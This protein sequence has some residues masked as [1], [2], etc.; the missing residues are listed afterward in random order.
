MQTWIALFRGINV[1][2]R[3]KMSMAAL[4]SVLET[5]GCRS[6]RTYIQSGNVVFNSAFKSKRNLSTRL[7]DVTE[8]EFG[9]R[10]SILLLSDS[11]FRSAVAGNPFPDAIAEPKTLHFFFLD[12]VPVAPDMD[13]I[14]KL[15]SSTERYELIGT[16][17]YLHTPNGF[18]RSKLAAG[19]ERRLGVASTA[20]NYTTIQNLL[21]MLDGS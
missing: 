21:S 12:A 18:G 7:R 4:A 15:A 6:V 14:A 20:R 5:T 1:G 2:G 9:F 19:A 11:D 3:N 13:A 17:F 16:V 10:P 8:A